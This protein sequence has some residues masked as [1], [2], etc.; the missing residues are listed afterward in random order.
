MCSPFTLFREAPM[1]PHVFALNAS[2][3]W[4]RLRRRLSRGLQSA[5][6][7]FIGIAG[8]DQP[9]AITG[10]VET[11]GASRVILSADPPSEILFGPFDFVRATGKPNIQTVV[12][13]RPDFERLEGPFVLHVQNGLADGKGRASSA[14]VRLDGL[15]VFG[16]SSFNQSVGALSAVVQVENG[17]ALS[18]EIASAPGSKLT[19]WIEGKLKP[20]VGQVGPEGG[21]LELADGRVALDFPEG[22]VS[23]EVVITVSRATD[24]PQGGPQVIPGTAWDFGPD[25]LDFAVPVTMTL[26]YDPASLPEGIEES[27]LRIHKF[28]NGEFI[29]MDAGVVDLVN[30]TV[31]AEIDGF[32]IFVLLSRLF[33]G[34]PSD[35]EAPVVHEVN[36]SANGSP[37]ASTVTF[38]TGDADAVL[39]TQVRITDNISGVDLWRIVYLSPSGRQQRV[40]S[41]L[42]EAAPPIIG[43]DTNGTWECEST[44]PRY[45]ESGTWV[46]GQMFARDK[47]VNIALY[48]QRSN[49]FCDGVGASAHCMVMPR[50]VVNGDNPGGPIGCSDCT[51]DTTPPSLSDFG[52]SHGTSPRDFG[53]SLSVDLA[54]AGQTIVFGFRARDDLAGI[55]LIARHGDQVEIVLAAPNGVSGFT[56]NCS[57]SS[58]TSF[59]GTWECGLFMPQLSPTGTWHVRQ[60]TVHDRVG[61]GGRSR[62]TGLFAARVSG[63][64]LPNG[65]GELCNLDGD[66]VTQPLITVSNTGDSQGP[67][68]DSLAIS[69]RDATVTFDTNV[70]DNLTGV[71]SVEI[72]LGSSVS[73]QIIQCFSLHVE[74]TSRDGLWRCLA[75]FSQFAAPGIWEVRVLLRDAVGNSRIYTR[76]DD[77][78]LC[79]DPATDLPAA[80][81][82]YGPTTITIN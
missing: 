72:R 75:T 19:A 41:C 32:S 68:L 27:E 45:S 16:R 21:M 3:V 82:S 29:Q 25:G 18:V 30:R 15:E 54:N 53:S 59:D 55:D 38:R 73:T 61:N 66:C 22:A 64:F 56:Q 57:L 67:V 20:L 51:D 37:F 49:G 2:A 50:I 12:L 13:E 80:C 52:V 77:G 81:R 42:N 7:L 5:T 10:V 24:L 33:P 63:S 58:G 60:L 44:W 70:T 43:S 71:A 23:D 39:R 69:V 6:L 74:G 4:L 1:R 34:S 35:L 79:A 14:S 78:L 9:E 46:P 36:V 47:L 65:Q 11:G 26:A 8:C 40:V 76:R 28:E 62:F 48:L 31:S 17:S